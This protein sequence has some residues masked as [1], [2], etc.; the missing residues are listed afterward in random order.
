MPLR[1]RRHPLVDP[2]LR[3]LVP[4]LLDRLPQ[5]LLVPDN[6]PLQVLPQLAP[7]VLDG[8]QVRA[9]RA[10]RV[11]PELVHLGPLLDDRLVEHVLARDV[12]LEHKLVAPADPL[13]DVLGQNVV[14]VRVLRDCLRD[15]PDARE[16]Y[17]LALE[18]V[19][20]RGPHVQ[21]RRRFLAASADCCA[22]AGRL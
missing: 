3:H 15:G 18:V 4:R 11:A 16:P 9:A 5:R 10:A 21:P 2:A 6:V 7:G 12:L 14:H 8:R 17:Q 20:D 19:P 1:H 13:L 22:V